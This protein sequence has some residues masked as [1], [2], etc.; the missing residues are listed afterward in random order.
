MPNKLDMSSDAEAS[1]A[2]FNPIR[3]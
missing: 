2:A 3:V 1:L